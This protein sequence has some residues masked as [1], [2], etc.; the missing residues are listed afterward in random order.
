VF[1]RVDSRFPVPNLI[2]KKVF[3]GKIKFLHIFFGE[4]QNFSAVKNQ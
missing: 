3:S 1:S 2:S 4:L